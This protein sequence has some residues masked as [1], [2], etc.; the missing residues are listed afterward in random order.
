MGKWPLIPNMLPEKRFDAPLTT[1]TLTSV[2]TKNWTLH[3][4]TSTFTNAVV[5]MNTS[6]MMN[7]DERIRTFGDN[8]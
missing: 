2:P 4:D 5:T 3:P 8:L 1:A 7:R 6:R